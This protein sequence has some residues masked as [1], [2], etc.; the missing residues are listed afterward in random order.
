MQSEPDTDANGGGVSDRCLSRRHLA[1]LAWK[2]GDPMARQV[3]ATFGSHPLGSPLRSRR[4]GRW[5]QGSAMAVDGCPGA[6]VLTMAQHLET[7]LLRVYPRVGQAG[8]GLLES[9]TPTPSQQTWANFQS[10]T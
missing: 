4:I 10:P 5:I 2:L 1:L 6:W 7:Q 9:S 8:K 3:R